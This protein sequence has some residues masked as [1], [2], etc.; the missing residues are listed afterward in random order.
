MQWEWIMHVSA[1]ERSPSS[2]PHDMD[3]VNVRR[4]IRVPEKCFLLFWGIDVLASAFDAQ[5]VLASA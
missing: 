2:C 4:T 3:R 1:P 5:D